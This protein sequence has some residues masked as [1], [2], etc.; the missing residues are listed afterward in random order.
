MTQSSHALQ[1]D[2]PRDEARTAPAGRDSGEKQA[3]ELSRARRTRVILDLSCIA[4]TED[5]ESQ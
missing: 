2:A 1:T 3:Q 5:S 4:A